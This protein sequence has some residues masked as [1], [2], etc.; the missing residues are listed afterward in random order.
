MHA[1][2]IE[3]ILAALAALLSWA[4]IGLYL[5]TMRA[6]EQL[7]MPNERSMHKTPVPVG[8]GVAIVGTALVLWLLW[9]G[10]RIGPLQV[11]LMAGFA[12]LS[13]LSWINDRRALSATMRLS[14]QAAAVAACMALLPDEARVLAPLP[15]FIERLVLGVAWIW[16]INLFNFMDGIDG[17]A[18]SEAVAVALGYLLIL[19]YAGLEGPLWRPALITAAA[20]VGYL[21]WNWH[22]AQIFMG[23]AGSVPL[24]FLLGWFMIDLATRGLWSAALILPSYFYADA[25][26]TLLRRTLRG[27]SPVKAHREHF[28]QRAVLGGL[29][30][31]AVVCRVSVANAVLCVLALFSVSFP[32]LALVAAAAVVAGLLAHLQRTTARLPQDSRSPS[33]E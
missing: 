33:S 25:T 30:P 11:A 18:G 1:G 7:A 23:D 3:A 24:G 27:E 2:Y 5:R 10:A 19:S 9:P 29:S 31:S 32:I 6:P 13:A 28:Y 4:L 26:L 17:L 8:A 20:T 14:A 22:P 12:G 16:F 21:A 15:A